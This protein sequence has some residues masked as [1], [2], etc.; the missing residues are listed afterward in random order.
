MEIVLRK[1]ANV[2]FVLAGLPESLKEIINFKFGTQNPRV[3]LLSVIQGDEKL[4]EFYHS[5]D[6][7]AHISKIG[8]SFG[9]VLAEAMLFQVPVVTLLTPFKD[10]AQF[11]MVGHD[12]GGKCA[13]N[14]N[15]FA[16]YILELSNNPIMI[17]QFRNNL[18]GT[19]ISRF[20]IHT[21]VA[22]QINMYRKLLNNE[23]IP[24]ENH[25]ELIK[26]QFSMFGTS[27]Y[28]LK[29]LFYLIHNRLLFQTVYRFRSIFFNFK[30]SN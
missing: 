24:I 30:S 7:F 19:I 25:D 22:E 6:C 26:Q 15:Q 1:T 17:Q 23:L 20:S 18:D 10:N 29:P 13:R 21:I 8:E 14:I 16:G 4:S 12:F 11:E 27:K 3:K 5:L 2:Y 28:I 9:Y